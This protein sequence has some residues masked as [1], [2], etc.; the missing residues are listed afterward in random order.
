MKETQNKAESEKYSPKNN[1]E[2]GLKSSKKRNEL[3]ENLDLK[4]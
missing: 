3:R 4:K 2:N 1:Q